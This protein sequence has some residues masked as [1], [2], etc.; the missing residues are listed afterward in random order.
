MAS[1]TK[2]EI[3]NEFADNTNAKVIIDNIRIENLDI[4]DIKEQVRAFNTARGGTLATKMTS[5]NG[6]N[7]IGISKVRIITTNKTVLF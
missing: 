2:L 5:T 7:W 3:T 4:A 1:T 6:L